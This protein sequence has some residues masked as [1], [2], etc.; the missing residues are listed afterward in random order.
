MLHAPHFQSR[1]A[2]VHR[3]SMKVPKIGRLSIGGRLLDS[4]YLRHGTGANELS[5]I[6]RLIEWPEAGIMPID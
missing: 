5:R 2:I 4:V 1:H 6:N 3:K